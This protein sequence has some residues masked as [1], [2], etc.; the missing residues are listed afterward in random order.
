MRTAILALGLTLCSH[1]RAFAQAVPVVELSAGISLVDPGVVDSSERGWFLSG[2]ANVTRWFG[3]VGVADW[4]TSEPMRS[5]ETRLT[6]GLTTGGT[7]AAETFNVE[8]V[9]EQRSLL[10]G[11]RFVARHPSQR[12][13]AYVQALAGYNTR[14]APAT[15][16][17]RSLRPGE[18][19]SGDFAQFL[20][21]RKSGANSGRAWQLGGGVDIAINRHIGAVIGM[22]YRRA[23]A[24]TTG[25]MLDLEET[26]GILP[27]EIA[28]DINF[29]FGMTVRLG[30]H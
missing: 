2:V 11:G 13:A 24:A 15:V 6:R 1:S 3:I 26:Q 16:T 4:S 19:P 18:T 17:S 8:I 22:D 30:R 29:A 20:V 5:I 7:V 21:R 23:P 12:L 27:H 25:D 28:H 9:Q 14:N 10:G